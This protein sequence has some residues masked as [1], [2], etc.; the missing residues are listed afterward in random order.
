M[1]LS[2][3]EWVSAHVYASRR[4]FTAS[5]QFMPATSK[6]APAK[7]PLHHSMRTWTIDTSGHSLASVARFVR[8]SP[9]SAVP[10]SLAVPSTSLLHPLLECLHGSRLAVK[11][12]CILSTRGL[13]AEEAIALAGKSA[14]DGAGAGAAMDAGLGAPLALASAAQASSSTIKVY[15]AMLLG[16]NAGR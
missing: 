1:C 12:S 4:Q 16:W 2:A 6:L 5:E 13:V 3:M 7:G 14:P 9:A 8:Q 15:E 10:A 11:G